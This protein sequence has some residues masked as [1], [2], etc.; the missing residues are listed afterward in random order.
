VIRRLNASLARIVSDR[1]DAVGRNRIVLS[2][3]QLFL[4]VLFKADYVYFFDMP[5]WLLKAEAMMNRVN[6]SGLIFGHQKFENY[7]LWYREALSGYLRDVLLDSRTLQ[8][9]FFNGN[10][11]KQAVD[12]HI[13][14]RR[15]YRNELTT[16]LTVEL[17]MRTLMEGR[18]SCHRPLEVLTG[19]PEL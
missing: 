2:V 6:L 9:P 1:G 7:R 14:G 4:W 11:L 16:A 10:F 3:I 8:R 15:N 12:E 5:N 13:A 18:T 17:T 19:S